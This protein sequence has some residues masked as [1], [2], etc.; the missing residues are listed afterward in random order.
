MVSSKKS[1]SNVGEVRYEVPV[2]DF[3]PFACHI[4]PHT[5]LTKNGEILQ[6]IKI[7]GFSYEAI[8]TTTINLRETI[9]QAIRDHVHTSNIAIWFHTVR[10]KTDL[11]LAGNYTSPF[12]N[13]V[14]QSWVDRHQWDNQ[15]INEL[16][17]TLVHEGQVTKISKADQFL[18]SLSFGF[19]Q[20]HHDRYID[21]AKGQLSA[22]VDGIVKALES[23]GVQRLG[24]L[25]TPEG[26]FSEP[27]TFF[28]KIMH[29]KA[30]PIPVPLADIS[31]VLSNHQVAF[32]KN[33]M[34]IVG[35]HV[36]S[37]GTVLTIK[38]YHEVEPDVL[39]YLLQKPIQFILTQAV[40]FVSRKKAIEEFEYQDYIFKVS[41]DKPFADAL[42]LPETMEG[43]T[44]S[45]VDYAQQ[46][47]SLLVLD[48]TL[49][50][51]E[52]NLD[53]AVNALHHLGLVAVR[54]DVAMEQVYWSQLPANFSFLT[55]KGFI[56]TRFLGGF[57]SLHN[58]PAGRAKG[59]HWGPAVSVFRTAHN[60][61]Y[62]FNFHK[63]DN[64]HTTIVGP[65]GA[66][67]TVFLNFMVSE[68]LKFNPRLF[69][70]DYNHS[71]EVFMNAIGANYL[72]LDPKERSERYQYNPFLLPDNERNRRFLTKWLVYLLMGTGVQVEEDA[73][74]ILRDIVDYIYKLSISERRLSTLYH[75]QDVKI[76]QLLGPIKPHLA[77]WIE[78]G[79]YGYLFDNATDAFQESKLLSFEMTKVVEDQVCLGP[80][81]GYILHRLELMLDG[82]PTLFVLDEAWKLVN[83]PIFAPELGAWLDRLKEKNA[84]VIF[85]TEVMKDPAKRKITQAVLHKVA[86]EIYLPN[87]EPSDAYSVIWNLSEIE[88]EQLVNLDNSKHEFMFRHSGATVVASLDLK[89]MDDILSVLAADSSSIQRMN[90][91]KSKVGEQPDDW[92]PVFYSSAH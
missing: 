52:T 4:D 42:K 17:I 47:I 80:L 72:I 22:I 20:K 50:A 48:R 84:M 16:Y 43:L 74:K 46:Q 12:A 91:I 5:I 2:P 54:E 31:E 63:G 23:Y 78:E 15:F 40:V 65:Q 85:A 14:H 30:E 7:T 82:T 21:K 8:G 51:M 41:G 19:Y 86:T 81:L 10:R 64:G 89:G 61:P 90:E 27:I 67:K 49:E 75:S 56:N 32:G 26:V 88:I 36:K 55:R 76:Q 9:R 29:L 71:A 62:F 13:Y 24:I 60:T 59:N 34:E 45:A 68:A 38:E 37:F 11:S 79:A 69:F 77:P 57:S 73:I 53:I 87:P 70:F 3:I 44:K 92:L 39:D 25:E 6:T 83:N 66:G 1:L 28:G 58:F 18:R 35:E 33:T